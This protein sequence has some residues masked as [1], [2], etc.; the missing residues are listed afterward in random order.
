[1]QTSAIPSVSRS[2]PLILIFISAF[3]SICLFIKAAMNMKKD[4]TQGKELLKQV[5]IIFPYCILILAY[6]FLIDKIGYIMSTILFMLTS[7]ISLKFKNKILMI[8]VC[9]AVTLILYF[10]FT[11]FLS[12]LLPKGRWIEGLF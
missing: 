5:K 9:L 4:F 2:Y 10:V 12:V 6:L 8:I 7:L 1:M 11:E 3:M